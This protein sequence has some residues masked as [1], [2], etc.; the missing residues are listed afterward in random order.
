M[1]HY[2][3]LYEKL[4]RDGN[5]LLT[6]ITSFKVIRSTLENF[7]A[8]T[9]NKIVVLDVVSNKIVATANAHR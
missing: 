4:P 3:V 7:S 6:V 9:S 1:V 8:R 2:Y 5:K